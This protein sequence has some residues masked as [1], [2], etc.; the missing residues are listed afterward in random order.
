[1]AIISTSCCTVVVA[2]WRF[3]P[4]HGLESPRSVLQSLLS[5]GMLSSPSVGGST[6]SLKSRIITTI[7]G[8]QFEVEQK[9]VLGRRTE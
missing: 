7:P 8:V 4:A 2:A 9:A 1:M 6:P 3:N 5:L